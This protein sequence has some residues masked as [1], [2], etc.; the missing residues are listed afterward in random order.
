MGAATVAE[1]SLK[2]T[3]NSISNAFPRLPSLRFLDFDLKNYN[4][5]FVNFAVIVG[6]AALAKSTMQ[7]P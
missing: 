7:G 1:N 3:T 2:T 4:K 6:V 5:S